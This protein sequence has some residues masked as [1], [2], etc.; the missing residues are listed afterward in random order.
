M[1]TISTLRRRSPAATA[2]GLALALLAAAQPAFGLT[3][4]SEARLTA[5]DNYRPEIVRTGPSAAVAVWQ[6]GSN[7]YARRTA[8]GGRSW[9]PVVRV[10]SGIRTTLSASGAAG[11]VDLAYVVQVPSPAGGFAYR[12]YYRRS[13]DGGATWRAPVALTSPESKIAD[14]DV[15]R[16]PGGEVSVVWTG[17]LTGNLY[18]RTSLDGGSTF[19][20]ARYVGRTANWEPGRTVIYRGD[21][22]IAIGA[23]VTHVAYTSARDTMSVRRSVNRGVSWSAAT[24]LGTSV[25]PEYSLVADGSRAIIGYTSSVSGAMR[26]S[27]RRTLDKGAS[28]SSARLVAPLAT[29]Q[30]STTPQFAFDGGVLAVV[31]KQGRPG[32]S[33]V[34]YAHSG[35]FGSR[36][37]ATLRVSAVRVADSDPEPGGVAVL[38]SRRLAGYN[39]NRGP[40][41][42]GLWIRA[43]Q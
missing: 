14:Q 23:G 8:D 34:W 27:Y 43:G 38:G 6:R 36:W 26:A 4:T 41:S 29:G 31:F 22:A 2:F 3:W 37:S 40:G 16:H 20:P 30:F 33:P 7:G 25:G 28:W 5:Y 18:M 1:T 15:A 9:S 24:R 13:L 42:E 19:G 12:L 17:L 39:E 32:L 11:R 10:A 35:D 21:P